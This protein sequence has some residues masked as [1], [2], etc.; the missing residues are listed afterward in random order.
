[1]FVFFAFEL[2]G[3]RAENAGTDSA[4]HVFSFYG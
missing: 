2:E 1:M 3:V 4:G